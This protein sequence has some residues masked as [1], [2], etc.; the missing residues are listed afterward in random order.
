[1]DARVRQFASA[2]AGCFSRP[3]F[4]HFVTVLV[5]LLLC[6]GPRTLTGLR[7]TLRAKGSLASLSRF[8]AEAPW[9]ATDVARVCR[10]RFDAQLAPLVVQLHA[11][12]R[13]ARPKRRGAA[14]G[15]HRDWIPD[16]RR[17]DDAQ[18]AW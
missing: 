8:L 3:Q 14:Q 7:R 10:T 17:L 13:V 6:H 15:I 2:F 11:Q 5:A 18:T 16:R 12:Q 1:V 9:Q 4:R